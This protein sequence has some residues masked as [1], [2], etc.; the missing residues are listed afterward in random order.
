ME[1]EIVKRK[2]VDTEDSSSKQDDVMTSLAG[3]DLSASS[4]LDSERADNSLSSSVVPH[5][6]TNPDVER[7]FNRL[8]LNS[9]GVLYE[10]VQIQIG[11]KS[12]YQ[13]HFGQ[14][15]IYIGNKV[16]TPLTS[17]TITTHVQEP[18]ALS[19]TFAKIPP[20]VV[21]PRS[22]SQQI[23]HLEC[24]KMF[25]TSP[26]MTVSFLAGSLQTIALRLPVVITKFF[27][28]VQLNQAD[29]FERWKLIGG[30][31]REAQSVFSIPLSSS[32]E[33]DLTKQRQIVSGHHLNILSD[34]EVN[35]NN[36][37]AAA[38]LHTSVDGKVG[39]LM[40]L[41]PNRDAKVG[42]CSIY[43]RYQC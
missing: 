26:I 28:H 22:Q 12:R 40:R 42:E 43:F 27:E 20:N 29:F 35:P 23:L 13:G 6:I 32:G 25:T 33:V 39:C 36:T 1:R 17:F 8:T 37:V 14:L 21:A 5:V 38:V 7:W 10:D 4:A 18:E 30:P 31:P 16:P 24:K 41:E 11:L 3:L 34:I 2:T 19:V 9:E 15:A